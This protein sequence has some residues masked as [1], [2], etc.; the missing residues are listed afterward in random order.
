M[1]IGRAVD[2]KSYDWLCMDSGLWK[3]CGSGTRKESEPDAIAATASCVLYFRC[4]MDWE[5]NDCIEEY[6]Y[7]PTLYVNIKQKYGKADSR[8]SAYE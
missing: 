2:W 6:I 4:S 5:S 3:L 8:M 7:I 1:A